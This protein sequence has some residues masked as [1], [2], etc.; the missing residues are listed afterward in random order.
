MNI[1]I[2]PADNPSL[3]G[4]APELPICRLV[5]SVNDGGRVDGVAAVGAVLHRYNV[6]STEVQESPK[7]LESLAA[8]I[9]SILA[10]AISRV[11]AIVVT[12]VDKRM[13]VPLNIEF[14]DIIAIRFNP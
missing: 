4:R 2:A 1:A 3:A 13:F 7:N 9:P 11:L 12:F 14:A 8:A 10:V 5:E 6:N